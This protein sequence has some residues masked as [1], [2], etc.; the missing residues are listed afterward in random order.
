MAG[1]NKDVEIPAVIPEEPMAEEMAVEKP[2]RKKPI[3]EYRNNQKIIIG[4]IDDTG[5]Q[6]LPNMKPKKK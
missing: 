5:K 6:Y 4:Y 3:I 1:K 2:V